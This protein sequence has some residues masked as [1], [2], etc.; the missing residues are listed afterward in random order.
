[1]RII[2][3]TLKG[4]LF[5]APKGHKTHPMGDKQRGALFNTLGDISGLTVL[6]LYA[7]SGALSLEAISRGAV[8]ATAIELDKTAQEAIVNNIHNLG[9][10]DK[11]TL[12]SSRVASW[13]K[14]HITE[15]FDIVLCD[16]P[17]DKVLEQSIQK[18]TTHVARGGI[19]VLSWPASLP[20]P[21][22]PGLEVIKSN[23]YANAKLIFYN[24]LDPTK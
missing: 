4:R 21:E 13:S 9:L 12:A 16:P 3:G 10:H 5:D 8:R 7:G 23:T 11:V 14:K 2:A 17:Y 18:L 6:D 15:W 19:F 22:F 1:M 20:I 24:K